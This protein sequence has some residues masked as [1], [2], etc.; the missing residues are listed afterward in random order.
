MLACG[1][2]ATFAPREHPI[3]QAMNA[4]RTQSNTDLLEALRS[5]NTT[6]RWAAMAEIRSL[7]DDSLVPLLVAGG[8]LLGGGALGAGRSRGGRRGCLRPAVRCAILLAG[9]GTRASVGRYP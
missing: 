4:K 5:P 9:R 7:E 3:P 6:T 1:E 8:A 2:N